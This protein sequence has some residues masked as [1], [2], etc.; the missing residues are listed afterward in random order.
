M[1]LC[2]NSKVAWTRSSCLLGHCNISQWPV[3]S[4]THPWDNGIVGE[5]LL[6]N[7]I[8]SFTYRMISSSPS[9]ICIST[10]VHSRPP[11]CYIPAT[12]HRLPVTLGLYAEAHSFAV[13]PRYSPAPTLS[14]VPETNTATPLRQKY[15]PRDMEKCIR[16]QLTTSPA[17]CHAAIQPACGCNDVS[18]ASHSAIFVTTGADSHSSSCLVIGVHS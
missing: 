12:D 17:M 14:V 8:V 6:T 15:G 11:A 10:Y 7:L 13:F 4:Q 9:P 1:P 16:K 3:P 18:D 2:S 5:E